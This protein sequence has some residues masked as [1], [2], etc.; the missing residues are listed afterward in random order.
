[1][2]AAL[3]SLFIAVVAL[4]SIPL[5][6]ARVRFLRLTAPGRI[7]HLTV[8]PD[9]YLK[10]RRLGLERPCREVIVIPPGARPNAAL[11]DYWR[12]HITVVDSPLMSALLARTYYFPFIE[13]D[14]RQAAIN[15]TVPY[16]ADLRAW[17]DR[18]ALLELKDA[19]RREGLARLA[20][21]GVPADA[22]IVCF[23]CREGGYSPEDEHLHSFRNCS[24]ENYLPAVAELT[25]R[26]IWCVRMG[27]PSMRPIPPQERVIDYAHLPIRSDAMDL[28]L[29]AHGK[30]FLGSASGLMYLASIFGKQTGSA[31]HVPLST[32]TGH[33]PQDVAIPKLIWSERERR[34]LTF[35]EIM[36][37]PAANYRF[38]YLYRQDGLVTVENTAEEVR[39]LALEMLERAEGRVQYTREDEERQARFK[40]L[41]RPGH[42]GYGGQTRVGR[43]FLRKYAHLLGD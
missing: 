13:R 26:G 5:F 30:F 8:E 31:N 32:V 15:E 3:S 41:F 10:R 16:L 25:R 34:H 35:A 29:C 43:D 4:L 6:L 24:V 12:E 18:P 11:L 14:I 19:Q 40:A 28:F 20:E 21:L 2:R 38:T 9:V 27:D 7:G 36:R 1:V 33:Y 17:G 39:D 22:P 23:H 37:S 42:W